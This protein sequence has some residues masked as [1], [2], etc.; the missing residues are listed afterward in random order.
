MVHVLSLQRDAFSGSGQH[1]ATVQD[2][3]RF[4]FW[5]KRE[6]ASDQQLF[7]LSTVA[8]QHETTFAFY[9]LFRYRRV[10]L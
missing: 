1:L 8:W 4:I 7:C 2:N 10:Q 9:S 3:F 5:T 6:I